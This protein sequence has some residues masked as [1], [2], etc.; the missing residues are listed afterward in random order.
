MPNVY[1]LADYV[2]ALKDDIERQALS[3]LL[4][5][6]DWL[7]R[8]PVREVNGLQAAVRVRT[9][10]PQVGYR[11][12]GEAF[13]QVTKGDRRMETYELIE[14]GGV[15]DIDI[16][17][18][19]IPESALDYN[20]VQEDLDDVLRATRWQLRDLIFNGDRTANEKTFDGIKVW[21][22]RA[23]NSDQVVDAGGLDI[24]PTATNLETNLKRLMDF[25]DDAIDRVDGHEADIIFVSRLAFLRLQAI[26]RQVPNLFPVGENKLELRVPSYHG[27]AIVRAGHK[28]GGKK[29]TDA[30]II[31]D[32]NE[33]GPGT[34]TDIYVVRLANTGTHGVRLLARGGP[35]LEELG[36]DPTNGVTW[37]WV[38]RWPVGLEIKGLRPLARIKNVKVA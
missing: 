34:G 31:A 7:Q 17:Y 3:D 11:R 13:P 18:R 35:K 19:E 27:A 30:Q 28:P 36:R 24:S 38:F 16:A 29:T 33:S 5:G 10:L 12:I 23:A 21:A 8:F 2:Q 15:I 6:E 1:T 9:S 32:S 22:N 20:P 26:S 4:E 25:L 14:V 37:R